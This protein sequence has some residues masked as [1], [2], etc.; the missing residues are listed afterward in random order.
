M[1][2]EKQSLF[3]LCKFENSCFLTQRQGFSFK[4]KKTNKHSFHVAGLATPP[5][6]YI[7]KNTLTPFPFSPSHT[8]IHRQT[9]KESHRVTPSLISE[10]VMTRSA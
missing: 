1:L 3:M 10:R 2:K 8:L 7:T 9:H 5:I 6:L 4:K